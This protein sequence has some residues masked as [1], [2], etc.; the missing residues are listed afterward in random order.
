MLL[1]LSYSVRSPFISSFIYELNRNVVNATVR[2]LDKK[3]YKK[4]IKQRAMHEEEH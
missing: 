2:G 4:R 1:K 3:F